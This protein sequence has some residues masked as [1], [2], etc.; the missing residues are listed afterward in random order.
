MYEKAGATD[1][2][3]DQVSLCPSL[4]SYQ[5]KPIPLAGAGA[6]GTCLGVPRVKVAVML[7]LASK[8]GRWSPGHQPQPLTPLRG[9]P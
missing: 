7:T 9:C 5:Q 4:V 6:A 3:L 2:C 8:L 1:N